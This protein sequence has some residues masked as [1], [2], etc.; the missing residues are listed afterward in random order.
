MGL[1]GRMVAG[2]VLRGELLLLC[3]V[4]VVV[5]VRSSQCQQ[6]SCSLGHLSCLTSAVS[7]TRTLARTNIPKTLCSVVPGT[8]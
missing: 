1:L 6:L 8:D 7:L 3:A 4:L 2:A 5:L